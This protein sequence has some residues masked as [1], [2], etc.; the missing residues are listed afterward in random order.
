MFCVQCG[1]ELPEGASVCPDCGA[2]VEKEI[3]FSDVTSYAGQKAQQVS[4][5]IQSQ[6]QNFR[7]A[8]E[9][10]AESRKVKDIREL[11]VNEEE[12]Q[13]A[14]I[15]G[16]CL[17][18]MLH[19][20]V[21]GKGFG[22]LTDRRL[23]YRGKCFYRIGGRYMKSDEDCT[24][25]LQDITSSGFT[26]ARNLIWMALATLSG[27]A[28]LFLFVTVI[29]AARYDR[30][31]FT[32]WLF[33]F[34]MVTVL[35]SLL[36]VISKKTIYEVTFAGGTLSIKASSYGVQEVRAF[37]KALRREKDSLLKKMH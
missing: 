36:F 19:S 11:F 22:V 30:P 27:M 28:S 7:Q 13:K 25:D 16:G 35:F 37:D 6:V 3:N 18:N 2:K 12:Q 29:G 15:G 32:F 34:L 5:S 24:V 21:L 31:F 4:D 17:S 14:V 10:A 8:Q 1:K 20:G 33:A 23:Y 9:E 26:Y